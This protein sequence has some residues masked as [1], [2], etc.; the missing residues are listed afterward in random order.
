MFRRN[1]AQFLPL[2]V[3]NLASEKNNKCS[4]KFQ[5]ESFPAIRPEIE[6]A[7]ATHREIKDRRVKKSIRKLIWLVPCFYTITGNAGVDCD[8]TPY[9]RLEI[10]VCQQPVLRALDEELTEA[11]ARAQHRGIIDRPAVVERRNKIARQCWREPEATL[12]A[13]LLNAEL[14]EFES[15]LIELGEMPGSI[16]T[17]EQAPVWQQH[18]VLLEK[19]LALAEN[20]LRSTGKPDLTIATILDLI[21][22]QS[23]SHRAQSGVTENADH[24]IADLQQRLASGC[25]HA[26]YGNE[27]RAVLAAHKTS[28]EKVQ[29]QQ[30]LISSSEFQ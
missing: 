7:A 21:R 10:A 24:S 3:E 23:D 5:Q 16:S 28:C 26:V 20:S 8:G 6:F 13:C 14:N 4:G 1:W 2:V 11:Y 18:S 9:T 22:L 29:E 30:S 19:Q 25:K 27:W 17:I 12:S 15:I